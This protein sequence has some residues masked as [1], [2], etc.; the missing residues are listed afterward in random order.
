M[1]LQSNVIHICDKIRSELPEDFG[2]PE[3]QQQLRHHG[4]VSA[5]HDAG[6]ILAH[7][8]GHSEA[9]KISNIVKAWFRLSSSSPLTVDQS[10]RALALFLENFGSLATEELRREVI[11]ELSTEVKR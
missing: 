1:L 11:K 5:V 7:L 10:E 4:Y 2:I 8:R 6:Q 3:I 9:R